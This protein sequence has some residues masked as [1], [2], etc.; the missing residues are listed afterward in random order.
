MRGKQPRSIVLRSVYALCVLGCVAT[1]LLTPTQTPPDKFVRVIDSRA[2]AIVEDALEDAVA[3]ERADGGVVILVNT[4]NG[5][6]LSLTER[7]DSRAVGALSQYEPGSVMKPL[8]LAAAINEGDIRLDDTYTETNQ[9]TVQGRTIGNYTPLDPGTKPFSQAIIESSNVGTSQIY[10]RLGRQNFHGDSQRAWHAYLHDK[11]ELKT[12]GYVS[13]PHEL[14]L[15]EYRY[16]TSAFGIG[17]TTT[18]M[19]VAMLYGSLANGGLLFDPCYNADCSAYNGHR[20]LTPDTSR[21]ITVVLHNA[22]HERFGT[23]LGDIVSGGKSGTAPIP[24]KLGTYVSGYD[25]GTYVGYFEVNGEQYT[26]LTIL[27]NPK[28]T[29]V[30]S[31]RAGEL[32][33]RLAKTL[34]ADQSLLSA[35]R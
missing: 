9:V 23:K 5:K 15:S 32:W 8:T 24:T 19:H 12:H 3:R 6:V 25:N 33:L 11:Y 10:S 29:N 30:A 2:Q 20:I 1:V 27:S 35:N 26:L 4:K 13:P 22:L 17:I 34:I 16:T 21:Q 14:P 28:T 18:P 31:S 7:G